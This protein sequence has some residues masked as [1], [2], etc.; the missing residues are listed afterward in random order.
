METKLS[1]IYIAED[2]KEFTNKE[3]AMQYQKSL[4]ESTYKSYDVNI[5]YRGY[6]S[7]PIIACSKQEAI[8]IARK[9]INP[10]DIK[11]VV[12]YFEVL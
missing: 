7:I 1:R 8:E 3:E 6:A 11:L 4:S 2:G 10:K 9:E 12:D 5:F